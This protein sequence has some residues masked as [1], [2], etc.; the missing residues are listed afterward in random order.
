MDELDREMKWILGTLI[1]IFIGLLIA[2]IVLFNTESNIVCEINPLDS[3]DVFCYE[4]ETKE[5]S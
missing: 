1:V 4:T 2:G 5:K 3:T